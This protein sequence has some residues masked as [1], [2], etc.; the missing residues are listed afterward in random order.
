MG[1]RLLLRFLTFTVLNLPEVFH[2]RLLQPEILTYSVH[3]V[4]VMDLNHSSRFP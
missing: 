3:R 2:R 1:A 4:S